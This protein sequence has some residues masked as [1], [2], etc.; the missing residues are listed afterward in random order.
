VL[1]DEVNQDS[2]TPVKV[3]WYVKTTQQGEKKKVSKPKGK[4]QSLATKSPKP[5]KLSNLNFLSKLTNMEIGFD[6]KP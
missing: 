3:L 1:E 2:Q 6:E 5:D 4:S